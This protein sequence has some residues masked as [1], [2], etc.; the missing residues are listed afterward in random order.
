MVKERWVKNNG[1]PENVVYLFEFLL[2]LSPFLS[3]T[4]DLAL[5]NFGV[6]VKEHER[7]F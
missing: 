3:S 6:A 4:D 5:S 1:D 2:F 7:H